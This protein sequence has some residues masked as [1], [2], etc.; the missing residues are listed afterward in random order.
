MPDSRIALLR[1]NC[2]RLLAQL[3]EAQPSLPS[4]REQNRELAALLPPSISST[5][6]APPPAE[7]V[8]E[9]AQRLGERFADNQRPVEELIL[10]LLQVSQTGS[11]V[12]Q[13]QQDQQAK[14]LGAGVNAYVQQV[15]QQLTEQVQRDPL[16][17]LL[18]R[19]VFDQ[20][21]REELTRAQRYQREF[22]LVLF[23]LDQFKLVNDRFGHPAGDEVLQR[24]AGLLRGALRQ[25]DRAFRYGGDEFAALLPETSGVAA[26]LVMERLEQR[27][28]DA[29]RRGAA[30]S[31]VGIS[32]GVAAYPQE[33]TT[34]AELVELAD[35]RLYEHKRLSAPQLTN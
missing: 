14:L 1:D 29:C 11:R 17:Q 32:Y 31:V 22:A 21:L 16:T 5:Y 12:S 8:Y 10:Q 4:T 19:A 33:A 9:Y 18:N 3:V 27:W 34:A 26:R 28:L 2:E 30:Q 20:R 13:R 24:F 23:D 35:S 25:T 15:T 7:K 6:S